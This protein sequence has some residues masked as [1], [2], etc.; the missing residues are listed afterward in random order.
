MNRHL[1]TRTPYFCLTAVVCDFVVIGANLDNASC[2]CYEHGPV[3]ILST[4]L[5]AI[6]VV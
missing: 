5:S 2:D 1:T 6:V 4:T 3:L